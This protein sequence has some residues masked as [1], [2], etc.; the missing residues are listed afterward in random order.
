MKKFPKL[1]PCEEF[2]IYTHHS[3]GWTE[4][5]LGALYTRL[6]YCKIVRGAENCLWCYNRRLG[7]RVGGIT[8]DPRMFVQWE[9]SGEG[10][11][12]NVKIECWLH[13]PLLI[14]VCVMVVI[15]EIIL[16]TLAAREDGLRDTLSTIVFAVIALFAPLL[17][18]A[19]ARSG[20][21]GYGQRLKAAITEILLEE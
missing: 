14:L 5:R 8:L 13:R 2:E 6:K 9:K 4:K 17:V 20:M 16:G 18:V 15:F 19:D 10:T 12:V 1:I 21:S 3:P 11:R 7:R